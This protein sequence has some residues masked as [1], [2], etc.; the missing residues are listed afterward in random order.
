MIA[1]RDLLSQAAQQLLQAGIESPK[2]DA[3]VLLAYA[4]G[5]A[6]QDVAT[7]QRS[8]S[9]S[10]RSV[11]QGLLERRLAREPLAYIT[12]VKEFWSLE[13]DVG[14]GVLIPRP[15]TEL[16]LEETERLYRKHDAPLE[17][18]DLGTGSG[19][20]LISFLKCYPRATGMGIDASDVA[21]GWAMRNAEKHDVD[22]RSRFRKGNWAQGIDE[23]FDLI[24][25]NPPYIDAADMASLSPDVGR[26]EPHD[27]LKGGPDGLDAYRTLAPQIAGRLKPGGHALVEMGKGQ[28]EAVK[29]VLEAAGLKVERILDDL[30]GI[31]RCAVAARSP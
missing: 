8:I 29:A 31:P 19:A 16:M 18:L 28:T 4:L 12:G 30:A 22:E 15:E 13:F 24:F 11:F 26:H 1:T 6:S 7:G 25:A 14:P 9:D 23:S 27:A 17:A 2:L 21:L 5:I 3:R 20:I 10:D